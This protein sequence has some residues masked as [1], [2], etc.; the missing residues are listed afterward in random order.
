[1]AAAF[2]RALGI[3]THR[4]AWGIILLSMLFTITLLVLLI[5]GVWVLLSGLTLFDILWLNDLFEWLGTASAAVIGWFIFP[6]LVPLFVSLFMERIAGI[7]ERED[8]PNTPLPIAQPIVP[9]VVASLKFAGI[10]LLY[11]FLVL[12]F[13]LLPVIN[14]GF[15]YLLNGYLLGRELF[16]MVAMRHKSL[17]EVNRL[18]RLHVWTLLLS[19]MAV[20]FLLTLPF[21]N[22]IMPLVATALFVHIFHKTAQF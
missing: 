14:I 21:V 2:F 13:Y 16:E 6:L 8:Y 7:V 15:Y 20:A 4:S 11:N 1:M 19:G 9:T 18:R 10:T 22:L 5:A 3:L 17:E 12:P